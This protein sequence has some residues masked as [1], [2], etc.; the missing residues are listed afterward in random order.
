MNREEQIRELID[1][2]AEAKKD[3]LNGMCP[4]AVYG[5]EQDKCA[6][7]DNCDACTEVFFDKFR[8]D[9]RKEYSV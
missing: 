7:C 9:L 5:I 6:S 4:F 1:Q 8:A 2:L 3:A